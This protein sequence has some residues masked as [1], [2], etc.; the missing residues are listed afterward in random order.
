MD[1][2]RRRGLPQS[3]I[4]ASRKGRSV[5]VQP[6]AEEERQAGSSGDGWALEYLFWVLEGIVQAVISSCSNCYNCTDAKPAADDA[7]G[8]S[9][10]ANDFAL[11]LAK[12]PPAPRTLLFQAFWEFRKNGQK[13]RS[14]NK[15]HEKSHVTSTATRVTLH[16]F[17]TD[18][19]S[20]SLSHQKIDRSRVCNKAP[21][22]RA[23]SA[24]AP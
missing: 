10:Q 3:S 1:A 16:F 22:A 6:N 13:R 12:P 8:A 24:A 2:A 21:H 15:K 17:F 11:Q 19:D 7:A 4:A 23:A 14:K 9:A 5:L 20:L 18:S